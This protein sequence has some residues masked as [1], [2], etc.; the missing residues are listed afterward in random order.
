MPTSRSQA[1]FNFINSLFEEQEK[2]RKRQNK[3]SRREERKASR[4]GTGSIISTLL[5]A[6]LAPP[7]GG[8]SIG[9]GAGI[10]SRLGSELGERSVKGSSQ[11]DTDDFSFGLEDIRQ[12]NFE[13]RE[14]DRDF[15]EGQTVDA[16]IKGI[17]TGMFAPEIGRAKDVGRSFFEGSKRFGSLKE[18]GQFIGSGKLPIGLQKSQEALGTAGG[19]GLG[20]SKP[21]GT[22]GILPTSRQ[23]GK[24]ASPMEAARPKFTGALDPFL[25]DI[26][27]PKAQSPLLQFGFDI[28]KF[29][30]AGDLAGQ[31]EFIQEFLKD[32]SKE[33]IEELLKNIN[34]RRSFAG[35]RAGVDNLDF[36]IPNRSPQSANIGGGSTNSLDFTGKNLEELLGFLLR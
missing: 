4:S 9:I 36:A 15:N 7:T 14:L 19:F 10:G 5:G 21:L 31:N 20:Q 27:T 17:T 29:E 6:L 16:I 30:K 35:G 2:L 13:Q 12:R 1:D 22:E 28:G 33:D 32:K 3:I 18:A 26:G 23:F 11:I 8:L 24:A 25:L 34:V